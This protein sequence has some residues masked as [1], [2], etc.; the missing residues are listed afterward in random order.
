MYVYADNAAT[1]ALSKTALEAMMPCF[2]EEYANPP[3]CIHR[4]S[5]RR[6]SWPRPGRFLPGTCM[7]T[8]G[9]SH[10]L[11]AAARRIPRLCAVRRRW[12]PAGEAAHHF[13]PF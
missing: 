11:P 12:V 4:D 13:H 3:A 8:P 6:K 9:R 10:L 1:T 7:R 5:G 2:Q